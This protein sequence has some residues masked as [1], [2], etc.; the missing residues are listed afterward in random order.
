MAFCEDGNEPSGSIICRNLLI[1]WTISYCSYHR[2]PFVCAC[3][4]H[5]PFLPHTFSL[6][7]AVIST[8]QV[9]SFRLQYILYCVMF[10]TVR[11]LNVFL[12]W[13]PNVS[14][15]LSSLSRWL[16]LLL[17]WLYTSCSTFSVSFEPETVEPT[18][19]CYTAYTIP[20]PATKI[21]AKPKENEKELSS[22]V[23]TKHIH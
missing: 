14:L 6:E 1:G 11:L 2:H 4:H 22:L 19:G 8:A 5:R 23:E 9:S 18:A 20:A 17:M 3:V 10:Q 21:R 16:Q 15:N 7:P 13:L 12:V